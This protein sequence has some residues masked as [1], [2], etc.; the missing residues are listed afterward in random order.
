MLLCVATVV[1]AAAPTTVPPSPVPNTA[2]PARAALEPDSAG[3]IVARRPGAWY[4][5][6]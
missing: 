5:L 4:S 2:R 1:A 3:R 6:K